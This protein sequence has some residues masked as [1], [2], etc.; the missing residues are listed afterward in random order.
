M[1]M[2]TFIITVAALG[3]TFTATAQV[4]QTQSAITISQPGQSGG[5]IQDD[6]DE[7]MLPQEVEGD[8]SAL[9][10]GGKIPLSATPLWNTMERAFD[11]VSVGTLITTS[12]VVKNMGAQPLIIS[13]IKTRNPALKVEFSKT[14]I[15]SGATAEIKVSYTPDVKG[16]FAEY[17]TVFTNAED[18]TAQLSFLGLAIQP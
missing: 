9:I 7:P 18:N 13:D 1:F 14:P 17:I 15:P 2:R 4:I 10:S 16:K 12:Y 11:S 5:G 8:R 6:D 3:M